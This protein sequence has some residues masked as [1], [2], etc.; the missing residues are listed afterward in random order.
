MIV[1][2][3]DLIFAQFLKKLEKIIVHH[4]DLEEMEQDKEAATNMI[5]LIDIQK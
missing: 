4:K 1:A 3:K 5:N 2:T